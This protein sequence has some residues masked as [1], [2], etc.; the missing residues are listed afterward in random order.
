MQNGYNEENE[1]K[2]E[3]SIMQEAMIRLSTVQDIRAFVEAV[4]MTDVEVDLSSHRYVVDAK[5]IM[6]I[7]SLDLLNPIKMIVHSDDCPELME[8][9]ARFIVKE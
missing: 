6:G 5:S 4:T 2:K 7:Y 8:K 9:L 1:T 3:K